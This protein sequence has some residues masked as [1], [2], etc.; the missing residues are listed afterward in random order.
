MLLETLYPLFHSL[1][2]VSQKEWI[3]ILSLHSLAQL[4]F[5]TPND[6]QTATIEKIEKDNVIIRHLVMHFQSHKVFGP[7]ACD[8]HLRCGRL[9]LCS[10]GICCLRAAQ[11]LDKRGHGESLVPLRLLASDSESELQANCVWT[12]LGASCAAETL[13]A[14]FPS[15]A[16]ASVS[17]LNANFPLMIVSGQA[18]RPKI[19]REHLE[20]G[21]SFLV[22]TITRENGKPPTVAHIVS[23]IKHKNAEI[24]GYSI[25]DY[26][27][28]VSGMVRRW[29]HYKMDADSAGFALGM[30][31]PDDSAF[32]YAWVRNIARSEAPREMLKMVEAKPCPK[33]KKTIGWTLRGSVYRE[34]M[35]NIYDSVCLCC[36]SVRLT[37]DTFV[38]G[39]VIPEANGG[40]C[41]LQNMRPIC[42]TCN[43]HMGTKI[44]TEYMAT[45]YP[46]NLS[47]ING[48]AGDRF[49][50]VAYVAET[51]GL[52]APDVY[53]PRARC[54]IT[55][56]ITTTTTTTTVSIATN[57]PSPQPSPQPSLQPSPK[58]SPKPSPQPSPKL[59]PKPSP[60]S[61]PKSVPKSSLP[62]HCTH[63]I[64]TTSLKRRVNN[65]IASSPYKKH[66]PKRQRR[67]QPERL[68]WKVRFPQ[69][70]SARKLVGLLQSRSGCRA[71]AVFAT[72]G[73]F[74]VRV[75]VNSR[76]V[77][78]EALK[79]M[80]GHHWNSESII[81]ATTLDK[82]KLHFSNLHT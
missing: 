49:D 48:A 18:K 23:L 55:P 44:L 5:I 73:A 20:R 72:D 29:E 26:R 16:R 19:S 45:R 31:H 21:L 34:F 66:C 15:I 13:D 78:K 76:G 74:H 9:V 24:L 1:V 10:K 80:L 60:K 22:D 57:T 43:S 69:R 27:V 81:Q 79:K 38:V 67:K 40:E 39:H 61:V 36:R 71:Q 35:G 11:I 33:R 46:Q 25:N 58:S 17:Q 30:H 65:M 75:S 14:A 62:T 54:I 50:A 32:G 59:S 6:K 4:P 37:P 41:C 3:G 12:S 42:A 47:K 63:N 82:V 51:T 56:S 77:R 7:G 70:T 53:V 2:Y 28:Q 8:I 64:K 68:F 52:S